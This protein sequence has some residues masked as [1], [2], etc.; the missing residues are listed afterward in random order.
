MKICAYLLALAL[1]MCICISVVGAASNY[2]LSA[3][4]GETYIQWKWRA[5]NTSNPVPPLDIYLTDNQSPVVTN[6]TGTTFLI[7][8]LNPG[9]RHN[10]A[11]WNSSARL[12]GTPELLAKGTTTTLKA[13]YVS[14]FLLGICVILM[15]FGFFL[16]EVV[17]LI[18]M[19]LLNIII[20]LFGFSVSIGRGAIPYLFIGVAIITG[21][22]LLISGVPKIREEIDWW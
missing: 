5:V 14:Y 9:E 8:K 1:L 18:L 20:C 13:A 21:I 4:T 6:Y 10:I 19:S 15:V 16:K 7:T 22:I 3:E 2:T 12:N 11:I 17:R